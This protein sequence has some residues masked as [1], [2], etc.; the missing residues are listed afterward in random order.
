MLTARVSLQSPYWP[1]II[2]VKVF[3]MTFGQ[4]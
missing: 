1:K 2:K 3:E 4:G